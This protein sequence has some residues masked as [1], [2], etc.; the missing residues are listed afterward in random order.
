MIKRIVI[1]LVIAAALCFGAQAQ[2]DAAIRFGMIPLGSDAEMQD[3]FTPFAD[4]LREKAGVPVEIVIPDTYDELL[5]RTKSGEINLLNFNAV[6][7]LKARQEG[8]PVKYLATVTTREEG[9]T[10]ARSYYEGFIIVRKDSE[11]D[12]LEDLKGETFAF[13]DRSSGSGYKMPTAILGIEK[14][15][16][17]DEYF[18]KYFFVGDHD[19]VASAVYHGCVEGGATWDYS[20]KLNSSSDRYGAEFKIVKKTPPIPNDPWVTGPGI[21]DEF[22]E[23]L[24]RILLDIDENTRTSDGRYVL[25]PRFPGSGWTVRDAAFYDDAAPY[26]LFARK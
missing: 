18:G 3:I 14:N 17:P 11:H 13:V 8:V 2:E 21:T 15:T 25:H 9:E 23:Q 10:E 16:T 1:P 6:S 24:R 4:Y 22:A 12:S 20:Y 5:E 26:L 19:E 7:Y